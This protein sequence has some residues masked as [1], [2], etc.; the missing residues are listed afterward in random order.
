VPDA[1]I[2]LI[3]L[4]EPRL[5]SIPV[6]APLVLLLAGILLAPHP[7][8]Q[9][10]L[11]AAASADPAVT[12]HGVTLHQSDDD[13]LQVGGAVRFNFLST[14]YEGER[15]PNSTRF[16][17]D[18]WRV[19][20]L[21][22]R[23]GVGLQFE[24][25]FYPTFNTHFIKEG[26]LEYAL[27]ER[28]EL[29][30]GVTQAPFGNVQYNSHNWWFQLP[31][32]V[33]LEDDH[34][35][36]AK[37]SHDRGDG[38]TLDLAY[39]LQPEP[40][41]PAYGEASFGVG[42]AGRYAYDLIP[43]E[44]QS[45]QEKHQGNLRLARTLE[46]HRGATE[47]GASLQAG[48]IY[49]MATDAWGSRWAGAVHADGSWGAWNVKAQLL[50][51]AY[52]ATDDAGADTEVVRMG[53]YGD[54]YDVAAE[55]WI[56]TLGVQHSWSIAFGPFTEIH[57]YDNYS[58]MEKAAD[59]FHA[60]HQNVFGFSVAAGGLFTYVDLA[61]GRNQPWLTDSFGTGLGPGV[62]DAPWNARFNVNLG[63]YF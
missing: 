32:Y 35:M 17:W 18:T 13:F 59:G 11:S 63:Y 26:W 31:Y 45:N 41:G 14:F 10:Q 52:A 43:T 25:R 15:T 8:L 6:A 48:G 39:F 7:P 29:Q 51:Y 4:I 34:D 22:R 54:P 1:W 61:M 37:L 12:H 62:A 23:G 5:N 46:H 30:V 19:N 57:L 27:S 38:W 53:A 2:E 44:G 58:Y 56:A 55:A 9:A 36:G 33:G 16:T 42:G 3:E 50:R 60:T 24:Y 49:N 21:A 40:S 47:L 20:V 28:T